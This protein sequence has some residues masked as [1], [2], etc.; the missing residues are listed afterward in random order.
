ML[1]DQCRAHVRILYD[2]Y[3]VQMENQEAV[4][5]GLLFPE[6]LVLSPSESRVLEGML[7][8]LRSLGFD[9]S[10][11]GGTSFSINGMPSG[12]EGLSPQFL[13]QDI[14]ASV[15]EGALP[16]ISVRKHKMALSLAKSSAIVEG[17]ALSQVEID[18]LL[19]DL[20]K[21]SNSKVAPDGKP[22]IV[23]LDHANIEKLFS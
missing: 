18:V 8:D 3:I 22:I 12:L 16:E 1:V 9:L 20:F 23:L 14:V 5:Q 6:L 13:V 7:P 21:S 11:L 17:Q 4:T 2:R 10:P 15:G 19:S